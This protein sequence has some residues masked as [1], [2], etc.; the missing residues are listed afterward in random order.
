MALALLAERLA[1][2]VFY[3]TRPGE[4]VLQITP[5]VASFRRVEGSAAFAA[6]EAAR[7][8]W[9][10]RLP[11]E[12]EALLSWCFMQRIA[13]LQGLLTFCVAQTVNAV[14]L[15]GEHSTSPRMEQA[16]AVASLL[17]CGLKPTYY[18]RNKP[19]SDA[20]D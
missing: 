14:L 15:K 1:L 9:R 10:S 3:N 7:E 12:S 6:I 13:T 18:D 4:G 20:A 8:H 19:S 11:A 5:R 16:R 2:T 17:I